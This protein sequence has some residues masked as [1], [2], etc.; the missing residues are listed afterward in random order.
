MDY[1]V[2][3]R[4]ICCQNKTKICYSEVKTKPIQTKHIS[5]KQ[6]CRMKLQVKA[7]KIEFWIRI[8][9]NSN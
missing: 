5:I 6:S 2:K 9:Q 1:F 3:N 7:V 4:Q 8:S